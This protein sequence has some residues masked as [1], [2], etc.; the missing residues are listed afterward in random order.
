MTSERTDEEWKGKLTAEIGKQEARRVFGS[1]SA[2]TG[3]YLCR[4]QRVYVCVCV[5]V[6]GHTRVNERASISS[7][8]YYGVEDDDEESLRS[9]SGFTLVGQKR[10]QR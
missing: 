5:F 1:L 6:C 7:D 3:E 2:M 8:S 4:E 10:D 9:T